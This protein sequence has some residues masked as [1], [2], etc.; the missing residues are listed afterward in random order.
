MTNLA[1]LITLLAFTLISFN[2]NAQLHIAKP[3]SNVGIGTSTPTTKLDVNG[4][5]Y[6]S[7]DQ[8]RIGTNS[9]ANAVTLKVGHSRAKDGIAFIDLHPTKPA[10]NSEGV[11]QQPWM[12]R[13][14]SNSSGVTT[15][16]HNGTARFQLRT[17]KPTGHIRF[18]TY[19]NTKAF[20]VASNGYV[21]INTDSPSYTFHVDGVA[22]KPGG[23]SWTNA[24]DRR[25]KE[26]IE[27]YDKG[28][29][30][31]LKLEPVYY[32]YNGKGGITDTET[33]HV[34]LIAQDYNKVAPEAVSKFKYTKMIS[35]G[36]D[37]PYKTGETEEYLAIDPSQ[38]TFMLVNSIKELQST[39]ELQRAEIIDLKEGMAK[40]NITG[41][42]TT[43]QTANEINVL[44]E[45]N[46]VESALL[47][48]NMPN[49]FTTT[50][51][52]EY[53]IPA[54]SRNTYMS[55]RD[56]TGKEIKRVD[57]IKDGIGAI[58]LT[59]KDLAAGIYSYVLYIN[60]DIAALKKMIVKQ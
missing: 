59:A 56:I 1:K 44:L 42:A 36:E 27:S 50:T 3:N 45:G 58:E 21:G 15:F 30:D 9:T 49:P 16:S 41:A 19:H 39:I 52:I 57:I 40:V 31:V 54:N 6:S 20:T 32:N 46:G 13:F 43:N 48:Q 4:N 29:Q 7:G 26:N 47:A 25:L 60:D 34:G 5:I 10:L 55:F 37:K 2:S 12:G 38:I 14:L 33:R 35:Q 8:I 28:L 51:R 22:A 11:M 53:F 18:M 17:F 23:G 24:S